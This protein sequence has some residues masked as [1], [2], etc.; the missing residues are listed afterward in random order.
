MRRPSILPPLLVCHALAVGTVAA[1]TSP[2]FG[3]L[4][5]GS[6]PSSAG[7][8]PLGDY[9]GLLRQISPAAESGARTACARRSAA[10][11]SRSSSNWPGRGPASPC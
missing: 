1:Q 5:E 6:A 7:E 9:L 4:P 2:A 3:P 11:N 8:M 10:E